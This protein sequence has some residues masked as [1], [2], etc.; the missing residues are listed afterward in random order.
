MS[1]TIPN[2]F[3]VLF[4]FLFPYCA[5]GQIN[6]ISPSQ[7]LEDEAR[8]QKLI[9]NFKSKM[10]NNR[11]N[12]TQ[13]TITFL[14]IKIHVVSDNGNVGASTP[15]NINK[16]FASLNK[17][18]AKTDLQF[19]LCGSV[20][21][22][23]SAT[24]FNFNISQESG[25][26]DPNDVNNAINVYIVN[27]IT[28]TSGS[29]VTGYA[30]FPSSDKRYN[31]IVLKNTFLTDDKT[32][33]HEMGHFFSLYHTFQNNNDADI[34]KR[35]LVGRSNCTTAGDLVCD[36]PADPY[37]LSGATMNGCLYT[38]AITDANGVQFSPLT[39]NLM[40]YYIGCGNTMTTGQN[41]RVLDGW[42]VRQSLMSSGN[43]D[44]TCPA[45][46]VNVPTG[47]TATATENGVVLN[48]ADNASNEYGYLIERTTDVN[49]TWTTVDGVTA[50]TT[51]FNDPSVVSNQTYYYR[52]R[53]TNATVA[54]IQATVSTSAFYCKPIY[55]FGC[56]DG[57]VIADFEVA[58]TTLRNLNSGCSTNGYG[59]VGGTPT[60]VV[61][62]TTY[63]F[64]AKAVAGGS[65]LYYPQHV[66]IWI[67]A[68]KDGAFSASEMV[69]QTNASNVMDPILTGSFTIPANSLAG[70]T[71]MRVRSQLNDEFLTNFGIVSDPCVVYDSGETED[72]SLNIGTNAGGANTITTGSLSTSSICVGQNIEIPFVSS[73]TYNAGNQFSVQV[74][75]ASG[76][77]FATIAATQNASNFSVLI[78]NSFAGG[79]GYKFRVMASNPSTIGNASPA[80]T[81]NTKPSITANGNSSPVC[82]GGSLNLSSTGGTGYVWNGPNGYSSSLQNPSI[83]NAT[84]AIVGV[85]SVTGTN[86][87]GC[88]NSATV[89][90]NF[91]NP[92][93]VNLSTNAPVCAGGNLT[94]LATAGLQSYAWSGPNSFTSGVNNPSIPQVTNAAN[95]TYTVQVTNGG[96]QATATITISIGSNSASVVSNSPVCAG[97]TLSFT[98]S[99]GASFSWSGPSFNSNLATPTISA[100][101][102]SR[103]GVYSVVVAGTSCTSTLTTSVVVKGLPSATISGT[104]SISQGGT[105]SLFVNFIG[106]APYSFS[107][108]DGQTITNTN[109]NPHRILVSPTVSTSY[110]LS[111]VS[112]SCGVGAFNGLAPVT[113]TNAQG[114]VNA[115]TIGTPS[116]GNSVCAGSVFT[117]GFS[118]TGTFAANSLFEL[119]ISNA[120]G[121]VFTTISS[122]L[123]GSTLTATMPTNIAAG[124]GF[125]FKIIAS[126]PNTLSNESAAFDIKSAPTVTIGTN[127]PVC[128]GNALNLSANGGQSYAWS[129]AN[130]FSSTLQNP[131]KAA[132]FNDIGDFSVTVVGV[133]ACVVVLTTNVDVRVNTLTGTAQITNTI[134]GNTMNLSVSGPSGNYQWTGPVGFT[135]TLRNPVINPISVANQGLYR[136]T[137]LMLI[138]VI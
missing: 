129:S 21:T 28:Y 41:Q 113:V 120:S 3:L 17:H 6:C 2:L 47:L 118:K 108:S 8:N 110:T 112:N 119:Q 70:V 123:T 22:I 96:C 16:A 135:S 51:S 5:I 95:G 77:N 91:T 68:N 116:F 67:D 97:S 100:I 84:S 18:F 56:T 39:N 43:Y 71:R 9:L 46:L 124:N 20:N 111:S 132:T 105:A 78:G 90:A 114:S 79:S 80:L 60:S 36:T 37:A 66:A 115:I 87:V 125:R 130:G 104:Q 121:S 81:I 14:P 48:W 89:M 73:G 65:G 12:G 27:N 44:Y 7:S 98:A 15:T 49:L 35:E 117:L 74:S 136:V 34:S 137:I 64:T 57:E 24:Y 62:G 4:V 107:L 134:A 131:S 23:N 75:D 32:F 52:I 40:G 58:G 106:E 103:A 50:G 133:N 31:R 53:P 25:L 42:I 30:Y 127:S 94:L 45:T 55:D 13:G 92:P 83:T 33:A 122:S 11:L 85:Y 93:T 88:T 72:Y 102:T 26:C 29:N 126:N 99:G 69:F 109:D 38:G 128:E 61:A 10:A 59:V 86:S 54:S 19:F 101:S 82:G 1:R 63:S 76:N 138:T